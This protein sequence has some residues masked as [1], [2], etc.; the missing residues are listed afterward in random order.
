[1]SSRIA[2]Q[3]SSRKVLAVASLALAAGA[4]AVISWNETRIA[5]AAVIEV[6]PEV[7]LVKAIRVEPR[8]VADPRT[9]VGDIRPRRESDL[10]F[11]V[12][13]KLVWRG[14]DVGDSVR[15]GQVL[16]RLEDQDYRNRLLGAK[17]DLASAEASAVEA[18]A[19]EKRI[20]T[21]L[22]KGYTTR[23]NHDATVKNL[24]AAEARLESATAS[25]AMARDQLAYTELLADF[26]GVVT[27]IKAEQG[28]IVN[29]G[30]VVVR[31]A[32]PQAKDAVFSI[33]EAVFGNGGDVGQLP[34]ILVSLLSNPN[35]T[36]VGKLR[37]IAPTADAATRT[38]QVKVALE[39]PP[40]EMRF[41]ASVSGR[42]NLVTPPMVTLPGSALFDQDGSPAVWV[43]NAK[44]EVQLKPIVV[45]RY[46]TDRVVVSSGLVKGD[47]VVTAGVN[48]LRERQLVRVQEGD[49]R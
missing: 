6:A 21:L 47:V 39:N 38:Y 10:G 42:I 7:R 35:V 41:G 22:E 4:A 40:A 45:D 34:D 48:R 26:S 15:K 32:E 13:G 23:A 46:E 8:P 9:A 33:A 30:Q 29:T 36:A 20:K 16:A 24:R 28:Q 18:R 11:R 27:D 12:S 25:L 44:S 2:K 3:S 43:V 37:E 14:A 49:F 1:M 31:L 5:N 19:S 17:A